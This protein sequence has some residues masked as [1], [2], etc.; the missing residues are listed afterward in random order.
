LRRKGLGIAFTEHCDF[1]TADF[2][3]DMPRYE[4]EYRPLRSDS[5]LLGLEFS[6]NPEHYALNEQ[7]ATGDWDFILGAIHAVDGLDLYYKGQYE[8]ASELTRRYLTYACEMVEACGFFDSFAH[9]DYIC[10]YAPEVHKWLRLEQFPQEFDALLSALA[11]RGRAMEINTNRLGAEENRAALFP[12]YKRFA[13]LGGRYVTIG[14]DAHAAA[15]LGR[16]FDA[17][18]RIVCEAGLQP[19]YF[20]ERK[21][22][23]CE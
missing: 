21:M 13:E 10:R 18:L 17:A 1:P 11:Q 12:I 7:T 6:L 14:S 8:E 5:V 19:V 3:V 23:K 22:Y 2:M 4:R 9:I 20:K 15:A 16:H